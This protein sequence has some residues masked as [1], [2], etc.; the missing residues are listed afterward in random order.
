MGGVV[1]AETLVSA[2]S[3]STRL[4]GNLLMPHLIAAASH[5]RALSP[6]PLYGPAAADSSDAAAA[7]SQTALS[8]TSANSPSAA[9]LMAFPVE[10]AFASEEEGS[11]S[12]SE[13]FSNGDLSSWGSDEEIW[14]MDSDYYDTEEEEEALAGQ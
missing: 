11:D 5:A 14:S 12:G 13:A 7:C 10:D 3:A 9:G 8:P 6:D 2:A 1:A 4:G